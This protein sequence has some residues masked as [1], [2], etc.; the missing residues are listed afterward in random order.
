MKYLLM[1]VLCC[2]AY[3][4]EAQTFRGSLILGFN[5]SQI[6]G[7]YT[8]GY[9]KLGLH[10]GVGGGFDIT[11][12]FAFNVE[13]LYN[14]KGS[15]NKFIK[16]APELFFNIKTDYIDMPVYI[17]FKDWYD[18][19]QE[20]YKLS[21]NAGFSYGR[22]FSFK[23]SVSE[24]AYIEEFLKKQDLSYLVGCT[25]SWSK[26]WS[27]SARYT[28]SITKLYSNEGD[29]LVWPNINSLVGYMISFNVAYQ[30]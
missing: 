26:N 3:L 1:L 22:L 21:F 14:Q 6:D 23:T 5:A 16:G 28:R 8:A 12:R 27:A 19:E 17:S 4:L 13:L 9:N 15:Q 24:W 18:D 7:D 30:I 29:A 11:K 20:R 2:G 25:Y 10:A